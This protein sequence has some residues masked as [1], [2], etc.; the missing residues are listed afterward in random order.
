MCANLFRFFWDG[1]AA[2]Q[3]CTHALPSRH[4]GTVAQHGIIHACRCRTTLGCGRGQPPPRPRLLHNGGKG[5]FCTKWKGGGVLYNAHNTNLKEAML[6]ENL[7]VKAFFVVF[8]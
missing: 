3:P 7:Q 8:L 1:D 2:V 5:F 4:G 6:F